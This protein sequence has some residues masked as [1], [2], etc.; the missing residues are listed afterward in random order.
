MSGS[1]KGRVTDRVGDWWLVEMEDGP[2]A[3]S[4]L[5]IPPSCCDV[6]VKIGTRVKL[7]YGTEQRGGLWR[8]VAELPENKT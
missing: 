8:I 5:Y 3:F 2:L 1:L 6:P 4:K 7:K